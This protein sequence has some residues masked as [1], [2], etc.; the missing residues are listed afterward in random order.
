MRKKQMVHTDEQ[1]K[2]LNDDRQTE[3]MRKFWDFLR[4]SKQPYF[5]IEEFERV[6]GYSGQYAQPQEIQRIL[7]ARVERGK[8][9]TIQVKVPGADI[10]LAMEAKVRIPGYLVNTIQL[11]DYKPKFL[12]VEEGG[13]LRSIFVDERRNK[14]LDTANFISAPKMLILHQDEI[15]LVH[16]PSSVR[17]E[18]QKR[19]QTCWATLLRIDDLSLRECYSRRMK[20]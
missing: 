2:V 11:T 12:K 3:T 8:Y 7:G 1:Q 16:E 6:S 15:R 18:W 14:V 10:W 5:A 4:A 9:G 17:V 13:W 19:F 20:R